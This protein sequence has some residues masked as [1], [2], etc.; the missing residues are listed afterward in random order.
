[1]STEESVDPRQVEQ[2]QAQIRVLV[3]EIV[4]MA[5]QDISTETFFAEFTARVVQALVAVGGAVWSV[6][7]QGGLELTHQLNFRETGLPDRQEDL[8]RHRRLV[9][10]SFAAKDGLIVLPQTGGTEEQG[11]NP[12]DFLLLLAPVLVGEAVRH[13]VEVFQRPNPS[14]KT[15]RG[16]LRFLLQM[17][18]LA[19]DFLKNRQLRNYN[20]R[21]ALWQQLEQFTRSV[22]GSLDPRDVA[23][24]IA[25]EGRNLIGCDRVS[26]ALRKGR[27]C[28]IEAIS[29]QD[30]FDTRSNAVTLL[31]ELATTVVA[32]G[33]PVWYT[34]D[35]RDFPPQIEQA[36]QEYVDESHTKHIAVLPIVCPDSPDGEPSTAPPLGALIVEQIEDTRPREGQLQRVQVVCEHSSAALSNALEHHGL[37]LMPVW[38]TI[39]KSRVLVQARTLPKTLLVLGAIVAL[40]LVL[41]FVP[42]DF[43]LHSNGTLQPV[44]RR[45]VFASIDGTV[46]AVFVEH[47]SHVQALTDAYRDKPGD[48]PQTLEAKRAQRARLRLFELRNTQLEVDMANVSGQLAATV[49]QL[50]A[51]E[52]ALG[53]V[54][55]NASPAEQ[56]RLAGERIELKQKR[57]SLEEQ[58]RLYQKKRESLDV[59]SPVD[60]VVTTWDIEQLLRKRPVRQ[61]QVLAT[62]ADT[63]GQWELELKMPEDRVGHLVEAQREFGSDLAV[64]YRLATNP[65]TDYVGRVK[66]VELSAE[67]RGDEGNTVLVKVAIDEQDRDHFRPG[68][69]VIAKVHC[70]KRALGYVWFHDVVDFI[71]KRVLFKL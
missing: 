53:G 64:T 38:R 21:Q 10:N 3:D 30:T 69:E 70:G 50:D 5:R 19:T 32:G 2:A 66:S 57:D 49:A 56:V 55:A 8:Q 41:T 27:K 22:H 25:N 12:T 13:V 7:P 14:I 18:E 58:L 17:C 59:F 37:F 45:D 33:E 44:L 47:G 24:T 43:N 16:Y 15:Q 48:S 62:V 68:S 42:Y 52:H 46:E 36:V 54:A 39:G 34:G 26:V 20:D 40:G 31:A 4:G 71:H 67:V 51:V 60:G 29:G 23:Y 6:D 35:T 65:G 61:G 1:M 11:G 9:Q 63:T 28:R